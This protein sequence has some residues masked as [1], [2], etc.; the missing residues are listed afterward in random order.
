MTFHFREASSVLLKTTPYLVIR[1]AFYGVLGVSIALYLG[2]TLL[3]GKVF[4]GGGGFIFLIGLAILFGL[5][6]MAKQYVLY[7]VDAGHIAVITELINTGS[8]PE[9]VSQFQYGKELVTRMFKEISILFVIDGMVKGILRTINRTVAVITELLPLPGTEGVTRIANTIINF[10]LTFVVETIL[11]YNL[12]RKDENIWESAKRGVILY[13][14]NWKPIL[15]T[16]AG[17]AGV[18][19]V[20]FAALFLVFLIPFGLL[21]M[22]THN[23]SLKLFWFGTALALAYGVKLALFKPFFQTSMIITFNETIKGQ[24]PNPEWESRLETAS[25]KFK[26]L[27]DKAAGY[28]SSSM[29]ST[30]V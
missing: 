15:I 18:N 14:Q 10:S 11:S 12:G 30:P 20:A 19:F 16:A 9:G 13:A 17:C 27:K 24:E 7:L 25:D 26:E 3:I 28:V 1:M 4:G 22:T 5:L 21:A 8:L 6:R 29:N 23:E 2:L